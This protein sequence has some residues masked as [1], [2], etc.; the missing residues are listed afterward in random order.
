MRTEG[1]P[2]LLDYKYILFILHDG[3]PNVFKK[4]IYVW[5]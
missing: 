5:G 2:T 1:T 3:M 4:I